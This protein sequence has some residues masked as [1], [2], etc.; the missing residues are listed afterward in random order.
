MQ[1]RKLEEVNSVIES[2][3]AEVE[4]EIL[5]SRIEKNIDD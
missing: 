5:Q 3:K 2:R 4:I 1:Y